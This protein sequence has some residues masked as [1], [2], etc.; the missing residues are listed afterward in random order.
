M[1]KNY[2]Q[3]AAQKQLASQQAYI[4]GLQ[5]QLKPGQKLLTCPYC[6]KIVKVPEWQQQ[7]SCVRSYCTNGH[8]THP[9]EIKF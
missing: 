5:A 3:I 1:G 4:A 2:L 8:P 6:N 7:L 9:G